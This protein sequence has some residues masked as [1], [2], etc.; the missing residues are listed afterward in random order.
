MSARE[1]SPEEFAALLVMVRRF[2]VYV[3]KGKK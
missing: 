2:D 3:A 1:L